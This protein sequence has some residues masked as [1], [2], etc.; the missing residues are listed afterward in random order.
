MQ[1]QFLAQH[2]YMQPASVSLEMD[3]PTTLHTPKTKAPRSLLMLM[4][5]NVS[6]VSPD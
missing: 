4:A 5:A 1:H 3:E 6:A 2:G